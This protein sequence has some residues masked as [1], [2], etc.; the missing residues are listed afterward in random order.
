MLEPTSAGAHI[1]ADPEP[2]QGPSEIGWRQIVLQI[3]M[4][5]ATD[6]LRLHACAFNGRDLDNLAA[7]AAP[8]A[9]CFCDGEWVGEGPVAFRAALER[10]FTLDANVLGRMA[11]LD[12][13]PVILE[14]SGSEG[15]WEPRG[16]VRLV[17][18]G[19]GRIREM[20][21]DHREAVVR[22]VVPE[23]DL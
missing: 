12:N 6:H 22:S 21:I 2:V 3:F 17:G 20:H 5:S 23:P 15:R 9:P 4:P 11:R 19:K 13:E 14:V 8:H 7:Q 18:D 10:E 16:A 1:K